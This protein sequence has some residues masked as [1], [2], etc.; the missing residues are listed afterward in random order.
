MNVRPYKAE[1]APTLVRLFTETVRTINA[2]DYSPEQLAAWAPDPPNM[3]H[4]RRRLSER[5]VF[6]AEDGSEI[7]GFAT[8]ETDGHLDHMY[9]HW[10]FQRQGVASALFRC[11]EQE[12]ISRGVA[13]IFTES[14]I[15]A[16]PFFECVGFRFIATQKIEQQGVPF[17][18]Y[19]GGSLF[20]GPS[21]DT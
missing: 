18:N 7:V 20:R 8:F 19:R 10:R 5:I 21:N 15:T 6:V 17:I 2:D 11:I 13:R 1:D 14:S 4:W 9:V 12:V 16:R 3:D